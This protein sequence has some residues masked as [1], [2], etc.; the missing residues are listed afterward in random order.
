MCLQ[1]LCVRLIWSYNEKNIH[2]SNLTNCAEK[3][4]KFF[5][6]FWLEK[7]GMVWKMLDS[8]MYVAFYNC[9]KLL[10]RKTNSV[11]NIFFLW[12]SSWRTY[13]NLYKTRYS[14]CNSIFCGHELS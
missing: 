2:V 7:L 4:F 3:N 1:L 12:I 13:I 5:K 9:Y 8:K 14:N 6:G 10:Q 11:V